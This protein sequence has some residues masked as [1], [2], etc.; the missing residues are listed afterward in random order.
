MIGYHKE[1]F[2]V[3]KGFINRTKIY[4][5]PS[6]LLLKSLKSILSLKND[7]LTCSYDENGIVLYYEFSPK[8]IHLIQSCI[9]ELKKNNELVKCSLHSENVYKI[10]VD[11]GIN[12]LEFEQGNYSKIY[13]KEQI[14]KIFIIDSQTK[15]VIT[16]DP[17]YKQEFVD[18]LNKWFNTNMTIDSLE[19]D[20][21]GV[22]TP[23]REYDIPPIMT[24][25]Y[26]N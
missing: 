21:S 2:K 5:Y 13:N 12:Y 1:K 17:S 3:E 7:L 4:L 18:N 24:Q 15:K 22:R 8:N 14:K 11:T 20:T 26:D 10:Q 25:E 9:N 6:V 23:I 19:L 16:K